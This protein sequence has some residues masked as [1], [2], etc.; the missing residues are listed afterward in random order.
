M[1]LWL[2]WGSEKD[3]SNCFHYQNSTSF[4]IPRIL[5]TLIDLA[6]TLYDQNSHLSFQASQAVFVL[7]LYEVS[8]LRKS[9]H[10]ALHM[11]LLLNL[12]LGISQ[13]QILY[14]YSLFVEVDRSHQF[15]RTSKI[16]PSNFVL[17]LKME[18]SWHRVS[19]HPRQFLQLSLP[20]ALSLLFFLVLVLK[21]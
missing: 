20:L 3:N 8:F 12:Q 19:F 15:V 10:Q 11:L 5:Y 14:F 1:H 16:F 7:V 13:K 17:L 2:R 18:G 4:V 9:Y 6:W 21:L